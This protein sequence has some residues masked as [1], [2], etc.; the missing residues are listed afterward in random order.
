[1][2]AEKFS[3]LELPGL[4]LA[5]FKIPSRECV[6]ESLM[7]GMIFGVLHVWSNLLDRP[8]V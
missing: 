3:S 5:A 1:M 2:Q 7:D 4:M 8:D 6:D